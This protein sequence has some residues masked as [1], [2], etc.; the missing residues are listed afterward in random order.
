MALEI[1]DAIHGLIERSPLECR[2]MGTKVFQRLRRI[3]QLALANLVY[4][5]AN[6][7]RFEHS[8]GV[9]HVAGMMA[10]RLDWPDGSRKQAD[11]EVIRL[12]A[13]LHDIGHGPFS[14][15]SE[16][17]LSR[18]SKKE[19]GGE[20][21]SIHELVT[22]DILEKDAEIM[23]LLGAERVAAIKALL[24]GAG[25]HSF[26]KDIIS[27]PLDADKMDYIR[28]DSYHAGVQ[29]GVFDIPKVI[30]SLRVIPDGEQTFLGV[31]EESIYALEQL[32]MA[33]HH[34]NTQVYRHRI[35]AITDSMIVRG[36]ELAVEEGNGEVH[37]LFA[38]D[39]SDEFVKNYVSYY[40]ERLLS[41]VMAT[42]DGNPSKDIFQR[43]FDRRLLRRCFELRLSDIPDVRVRTKLAEISRQTAKPVES[44]IAEALGYAPALVIVNLLSIKNPTYRGPDIRL[45]FDG[46]NVIDDSGRVRSLSDVQE[47]I[48][49]TSTNVSTTEI[50]QVYLPAD[51]IADISDDKEKRRRYKELHDKVGNI[52]LGGV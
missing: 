6:H 17:L 37:D 40:D 31:H 48:L 21:E 33:R 2:V 43:L 49:N 8:V 36:L 16:D 44:K 7:T 52:V 47:S 41:V 24:A 14:H 51:D 4:P 35:R 25:P 26:Q 27:G 22:V 1:R 42:K 18:Y 15:V 30:E 46:I 19:V 50:L 20:K 3:R 23:E 10:E 13:L 12:T 9:M 38:Y 5:G 34:M 39:G 32:V 29:Y 11:T 28:R 45:S